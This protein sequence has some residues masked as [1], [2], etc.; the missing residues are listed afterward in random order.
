MAAINVLGSGIRALINSS[1]LSNKKNIICQFSRL[2][3]S[4]QSES[5]LLN[6]SQVSEVGLSE[7]LPGLALH[8]IQH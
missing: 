2:K 4:S 3:S 1:K 7:P 5:S 8:S 6:G